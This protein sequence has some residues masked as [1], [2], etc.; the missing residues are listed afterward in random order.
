LNLGDQPSL[1]GEPK[2]VRLDSEARR[3]HSGDATNKPNISV[4]FPV[5]NDEQT[6]ERVTRKAL[7]VLSQIASEYE[8]LNHEEKAKVNAQVA[9]LQKAVEQRHCDIETV[10]TSGFSGRGGA[11][12]CPKRRPY[13]IS[14]SSST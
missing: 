14:G 6:V 3:M 13:S 11:S 4:F 7:D 8:V 2:Q 12:A 5:Y 10:C 9:D 1:A